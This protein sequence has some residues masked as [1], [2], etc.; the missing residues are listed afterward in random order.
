MKKTT[1]IRDK[2]HI[3]PED[4]AQLNFI[5]HAPP[6]RFRRHYRQGLRS[7]ILEVLAP[8][9]LAREKDGVIVDSIRT[10]PKAVPINMLRIFRKRFTSRQEARNEIVNYRYLLRFLPPGSFAASDEFLVSYRAPG[11]MDILLCGCQEYV[12]GK[13]LDPWRISGADFPK[14]FFEDMRNDRRF[15]VRKTTDGLIRA[16]Q[17]H[18]ADLVDGVKAMITVAGCIPDL[19]G[20]G[21]L[22]VT[23]DG[24]PKLVDIN[25]I[26]SIPFSP[27]I[28]VDDKGYPVVDKSVEA[29]SILEARLPGRSVS[30]ADPVYGCFMNPERR[31]TVRALEERFVKSIAARSSPRTFDHQ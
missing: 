26:R 25:N 4:V 29:L 14:H 2:A 17:G 20:V 15:H 18:A 27:E 10:F 6:F 7:H 30:A 9:D 8:A 5:R 16:F 24:R 1:D 12:L 31:E 22:R 13:T 11:G 23:P 28:P 19:A 21:N 3:T